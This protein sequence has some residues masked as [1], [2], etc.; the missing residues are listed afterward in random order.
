M[1]WFGFKEYEPINIKFQLIRLRSNPNRKE[2][3]SIDPNS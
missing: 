3:E 1:I 2:S